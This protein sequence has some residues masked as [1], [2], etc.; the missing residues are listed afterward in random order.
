MRALLALLTLLLS[1]PAAAAE[2]GLV[3]VVN[4]DNPVT[5]LTQHDLA[6]YYFK[7]RAR[8]PDGSKVQFIDQ[9]D[10]TPRKEAFLA[11]LGKTQRELD[12]FWI[13]EKNYSGQSAPLQAPSDTIVLSTVGSLP[14]GL[15]YVSA[16]KALTAKVKAVAVKKSE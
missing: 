4:K 9:R 7:R 14:G 13:G 2:G 10:G 1:G 12:L 16:D 5:E 3:F 15:G 6:D 8:W 11:L